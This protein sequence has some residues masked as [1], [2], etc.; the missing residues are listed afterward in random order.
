[1]NRARLLSIAVF[2]GG[3]L[4][5]SGCSQGPWGWGKPEH[6]ATADAGATPG[7]DVAAL[8]GNGKSDAK[9]PKNP[10]ALARVTERQG[11]TEKAE[12]LYQDIIKKTPKNPGPHHRL[13]VMY[14][15]QGKMPQAEEHFSRALAL[16]PDSA[17][18]LSDAGYFYYLTGRSAE[19]ERHLRR[20]LEMD[21]GNRKYC[22]NLALAVGEQGRRDEAYALFRRAGSDN[23]ATAN[24]AFVLA[25]QG[26]Y[27]QALNLY[28]RVLTNDPKMHVAA[29]A[30]IELSKH[31][32]DKKDATAASPGANRPMLAS[33]ESP[34]TAT[35]DSPATSAVSPLATVSEGRP[36]SAALMA[37]RN[38]AASAEESGPA[39]PNGSWAA[40]EGPAIA[41]G[42]PCAY[43]VPSDVAAPPQAQRAEPAALNRPGLVSLPSSPG[44]AAALIAPGSPASRS[45]SAA[46]DP[47]I[48]PGRSGADMAKP[49]RLLPAPLP[50]WLAAPWTLA[51][52]GGLALVGVGAVFWARRVPRRRSASA[53]R[54]NGSGGGG[55]R[56]RVAP[57]GRRS[58]RISLRR[59]RA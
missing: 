5:A 43:A 22:T 56:H 50:G 41:A 21:P 55:P 59:S 42:V 29:D 34:A 27:R 40:G 31:T 14:A 35:E 33:H 7:A 16:K 38:P 13:G 39:A 18:L 36:V 30:M 32:A 46:A 23:E 45:D 11:Q 1:M 52:T 24:M 54:Q 53:S 58:V 57:H 20:A 51:A 9:T 47:Q 25:Q 44:T 6:G 48:S 15:T 17:E 12:R 26:E 37:R 3:L 19:A 4:I 49:A 2:L 28:D 10:F 8:A